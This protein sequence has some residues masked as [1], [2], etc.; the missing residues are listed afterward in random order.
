MHE[1]VAGLVPAA[2]HGYFVRRGKWTSKL[3]AS[4]GGKAVIVHVVEA[5]KESH[6]CK[7]ILVVKN[8]VYGA[9]IQ[10]S[11]KKLGQSDLFFATQP[12]RIGTADVLSRGID[13]FAPMGITQVVMVFGDMLFVKPETISELV[14]LH[15]INRP[16]ITMLT[17]PIRKDHPLARCFAQYGVVRRDSRGQVCGTIE[18]RLVENVDDLPDGEHINPSV[19]VFNLAWAGQASPH[20]KPLDRRDGFTHELPVTDLLRIASEQRV[21]V[22]EVSREIPEQ[23]IQVNKHADLL[24]A[25][26]LYRQLKIQGGGL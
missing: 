16:A 8:G 23:A 6:S 4:V 22:L 26:K 5:L 18:R 13:L 12:W 25:R 15:Q 9:A 10:K 14:E 2:G 1:T 20:V 19:Y 11:L 24:I 17:V 7:P 3:L 21:R